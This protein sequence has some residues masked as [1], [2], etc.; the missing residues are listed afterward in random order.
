MNPFLNQG[1]MMPQEDDGQNP[2]DFYNLHH[3]NLKPNQYAGGQQYI[4]EGD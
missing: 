1:E 2:I 3:N 4:E